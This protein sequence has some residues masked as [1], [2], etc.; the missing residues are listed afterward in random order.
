M[1]SDQLQRREFIALLGGAAASWPLAA[2]AQS[3]RKVPR[4][5]REAKRANVRRVQ[6]L[7]AHRPA[8][9]RA[10]CCRFVTHRGEIHRGAP[11]SPADAPA[12]LWIE[13]EV[14]SRVAAEQ[15]STA[16]P[17]MDRHGG[18]LRA[19]AAGAAER[20]GRRS[21]HGGRRRRR[22]ICS[23]SVTAAAPRRPTI[24]TSPTTSRVPQSPCVLCT[25]TN[26]PSAILPVGHGVAFVDAIIVSSVVPNNDGRIIQFDSPTGQYQ[27]G[28][29]AKASIFG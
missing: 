11:S 2:R 23:P 4:N 22:A 15:I 1:Q 6:V 8:Q 29:P 13:G 7:C 19:R 9:D 17:P 25:L 28:P 26:A 10:R 12:M 24:S 20:T 16:R 5:Q 18:G 21:L 3:P 14:V 27:R